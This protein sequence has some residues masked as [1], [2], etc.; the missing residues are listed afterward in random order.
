MSE[1]HL[2]KRLKN[3]W[4]ICEMRIALPSITITDEQREAIAF[5]IG[6]PTGS[7]ATR[8][9]CRNYIL[10]EGLGGLEEV[11]LNFLQMKEREDK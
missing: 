9:E 4:K 11:T 6:S 5:Q 8:R 7:L 10:Y 1:T 3:V 2:S